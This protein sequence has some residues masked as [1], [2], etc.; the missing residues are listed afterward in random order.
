MGKDTFEHSFEV[1]R[2]KGT[3]VLYG[4]TSGPVAPFD[5][6][7]LMAKNLRREIL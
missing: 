2:R 1:V 6:V 4:T 3:T 7:K 5:P